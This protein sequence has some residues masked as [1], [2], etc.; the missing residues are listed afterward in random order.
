MP[1]K[2]IKDRILSGNPRSGGDRDE[3]A[4][5]PGHVFHLRQSLKSF[6]FSCIIGHIEYGTGNYTQRRERGYS[7]A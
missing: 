6:G 3:S 2:I 7:N 1:K 4:I 5:L